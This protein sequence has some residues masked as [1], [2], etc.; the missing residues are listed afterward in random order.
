MS[1]D[2]KP[3]CGT[4]YEAVCPWRC[5]G[6]PIWAEVAGE[7][8]LEDCGIVIW[9]INTLPLHVIARPD[10]ELT[11]KPETAAWTITDRCCVNG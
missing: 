3:C 5:P 4:P 1:D 6:T 10:I 7:L 9:A 2:V 8:Q 11:I